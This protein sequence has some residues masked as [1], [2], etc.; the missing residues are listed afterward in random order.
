MAV[1]CVVIG[2]SAGGFSALAA[3]LEPLKATFSVPIVVVCHVHPH[4]LGAWT[5]TLNARCQVSVRE[6]EEKEPLTGGVVHCAPANYHLLVEADRTLSLSTGPKVSFA[7]PSIDVLFETAAVVFGPSLLAL[8]LTGANADG[9]QGAA[10]VK[11]CGGVVVAQD[12]TEA[13]ASHMPQAVI[14]AGL[15]DATET[16]G[17]IARRL[18]ML[19]SAS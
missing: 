1:E 10:R 8:V 18:S 11:A 9:R 2:T 4:S 3:I 15:S 5:H 14:K 16:L 13:E 12:P 7:R 17:Q 6:A 19:R